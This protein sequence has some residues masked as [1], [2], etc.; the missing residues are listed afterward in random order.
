MRHFKAG[1]SLI[2]LLIVI[3]IIAILSSILLPA[4]HKSKETAKAISCVGKLKQIG[5]LVASYSNDWDDYC[6]PAWNT[7]ESRAWFVTL[8]DAWMVKSGEVES[9]MFC[10]A[11]TPEGML[12]AK[13]KLIGRN[14]AYGMSFDDTNTYFKLTKLHDVYKANTPSTY[15]LFADSI[16]TYPGCPAERFQFYSYYTCSIQPQKIHLRHNRRANFLF[17]DGHVASGNKQ[18]LQTWGHWGYPNATY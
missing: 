11:W 5:S 13:G 1:F 17:V 9:W 10:P 8:L 6:F 7:A 14:H 3:V 16:I 15:D 12:D 2:E 18:E 4:L